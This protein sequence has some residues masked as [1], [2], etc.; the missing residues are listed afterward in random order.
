M[1]AGANLHNLFADLEARF[2]GLRFR[3]VDEQQR[4]RPHMRVFVNGRA[5]RDLSVGLNTGDE[6]AVLLA[7][8]GG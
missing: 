2:P 6:V 8:S 7:L 5:V 3:V 4:L 1:W